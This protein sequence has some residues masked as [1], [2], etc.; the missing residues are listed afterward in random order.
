MNKEIEEKVAQLSQIEANVQQQLQQ[1]QQFQSQLLEIESALREMKSSEE[2]YRI[3]GNVMVKA[4]KKKLSEDL[5]KKKEILD[6]RVSSIEK[7]EEKLKE[8][9]KELQKDVLKRI[10]NEEKNK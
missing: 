10:E 1:K 8:K 6:I 5:E 2:C 9:Q 7:Q 4:D 3:I